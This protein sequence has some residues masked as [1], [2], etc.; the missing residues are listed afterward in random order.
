VT[1]IYL[2]ATDRLAVLIL[3]LVAENLTPDDIVCIRWPF[4]DV[5]MINDEVV[6]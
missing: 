2:E 1:P 3:P 6:V 5:C 4:L